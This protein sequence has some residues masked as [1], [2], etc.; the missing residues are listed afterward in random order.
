MVISP[1]RSNTSMMISSVMFSGS[2]PTNTVRQPGG[3]SLVVGG[4]ALG[5]GG[6][7]VQDLQ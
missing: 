7:R 2:P 4:G 1:Q 6:N 3:R 5:F